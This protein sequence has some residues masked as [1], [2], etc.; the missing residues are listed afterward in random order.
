MTYTIPET[1]GDPADDVPADLAGETYLHRC[2]ILGAG[3][4]GCR[5]E[6]HLLATSADRVDL[7]PSVHVGA[8]GAGRAIP[9]QHRFVFTFA[10]VDEAVSEFTVVDH[11]G[12]SGILVE[13][14]VSGLRQG[15]LLHDPATGIATG[16]RLALG[17]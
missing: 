4:A 5:V 13:A 9:L 7:A 8:P 14:H 11:W 16:V 17:T 15:I 2:R 12:E 3:R 10:G 6:L 1:T